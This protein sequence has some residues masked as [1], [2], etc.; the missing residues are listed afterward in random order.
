[1]KKLGPVKRQTILLV[2]RRRLGQER[3]NSTKISGQK[4]CNKR[5]YA[6]LL[7]MKTW[8][9]HEFSRELS[10]VTIE[11]FCLCNH[12]EAYGD[13]DAVSRTTNSA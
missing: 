5:R 11:A 1:M 6:D 3:V 13:M 4:Q 12:L 9:M 7:S 10:S 2:K 8:S